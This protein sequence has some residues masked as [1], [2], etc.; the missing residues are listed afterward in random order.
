MTIPVYTETIIR[1]CLF[2]IS[3]TLVCKLNVV[4]LVVALFLKNIDVE[5]YY[6]N[7]GEVLF[8][9]VI[10]LMIAVWLL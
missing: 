4:K 7:Y 9:T 3:Y 2:I 10:F 6:V 5:L 1:S 8:L